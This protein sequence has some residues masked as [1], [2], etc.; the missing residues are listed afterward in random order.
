MHYI[1]FKS[2]ILK[3]IA[4]LHV[5]VFK[6]YFIKQIFLIKEEIILKVVLY[7]YTFILDMYR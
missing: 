6:Y 2:A 5:L 4:R 7:S 1:K 3:E